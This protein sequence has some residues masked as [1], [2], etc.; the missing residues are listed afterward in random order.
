MQ[1]MESQFA[2]I[3]THVYE[4]EEAVYT[5]CASL[6]SVNTWAGSGQRSDKRRQL[7]CSLAT[8][9]ARSW[10]RKSHGVAVL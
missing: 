1:Q 3:Y 2:G 9:R 5:E 8:A 10:R 4:E 7:R 6:Q